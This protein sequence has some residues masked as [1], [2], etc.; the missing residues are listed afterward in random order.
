MHNMLNEIIIHKKL[1]I[2][3]RKKAF[4]LDSF[5]GTIDMGDGSFLQSLQKSGL[6]IIAEIKPRSPSAGILRNDFHLDQILPVYNKYATAL[7]VLTDSKYF[8]GSFE[9]L[10]VVSRR[11]TLPTLC[12]DFILDPYQCY[13]ARNSGAQAVLLIVKILSDEELEQLYL[14]IN[15]LGMTAILEVQNEIEL[16]RLH[17]LNLQAEVILINNRNLEDF[18]INLDTTKR[19][20]PLI[21]NQ[22]V[23]ISASGIESKGDIENLR[24]FCANFLVGSLFMRSPD[25]EKE[26][27]SLIDITLVPSRSEV[28]VD[29]VSKRKKHE[30]GH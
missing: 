20:V 25:P 5:K 18:T 28:P 9:L 21:S 15:E 12:K 2:E 19:L 27:Q 24:P 29:K 30:T 10:S 8:S 26:F 11:S 7:S 22:T 3:S 1:E 17:A 16:E 13:L 14:Q 6:K 4:P 23:V